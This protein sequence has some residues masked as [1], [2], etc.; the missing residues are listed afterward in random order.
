MNEISSKPHSLE[1]GMLFK[2]LHDVNSVQ[3]ASP[4]I[5]RHTN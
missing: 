2:H 1:T 4:G 3:E 5:S